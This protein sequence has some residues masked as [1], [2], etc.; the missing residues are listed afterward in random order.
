MAYILGFIW[1]LK[2]LLKWGAEHSFSQV[3]ENQRTF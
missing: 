3:R 2:R 1:R